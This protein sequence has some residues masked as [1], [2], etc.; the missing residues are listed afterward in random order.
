[1]KE[2]RVRRRIGVPVLILELRIILDYQSFEN[3]AND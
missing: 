2:R 1:M 3:G